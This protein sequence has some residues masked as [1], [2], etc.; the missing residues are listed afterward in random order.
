MEKIITEYTRT[1]NKL[2]G[3]MVTFRDEEYRALLRDTSAVFLQRI[4]NVAGSLRPPKRG[5]LLR[6]TMP[7][8]KIIDDSEDLSSDFLPTIKKLEEDIERILANMKN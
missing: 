3:A 1:I 4:W 7:L 2:I 8:A 6:A 5:E